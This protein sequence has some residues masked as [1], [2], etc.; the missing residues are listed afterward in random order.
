M[1]LDK[2]TSEEDFPLSG[3]SE[4][5]FKIPRWGLFVIVAFIVV[6]AALVAYAKYF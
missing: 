3:G 5:D 2:H 1:S 6:I 4:P